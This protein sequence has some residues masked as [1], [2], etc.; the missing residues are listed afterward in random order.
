MID[1]RKSWRRRSRVSA[2][3]IPPAAYGQC[4]RWRHSPRAADRPPPRETGGGHSADGTCS[5]CRRSRELRRYSPG[6]SHPAPR[7]VLRRS[8]STT[9]AMPSRT[10]ACREDRGP[11]RVREAKFACDPGPGCRSTGLLSTRIP[12]SRR[13][14]GTQACRIDHSSQLAKRLQIADRRLINSRP[15]HPEKK[16]RDS[17]PDHRP[18]DQEH[19]LEQVQRRGFGVVQA[20]IAHRGRRPGSVRSVEVPQPQTPA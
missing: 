2:G 4:G 19:V 10:S 1:C 3:C 7:C 14:R 16:I 17:P 11:R 20:E 6:R 12:G 18:L 9:V 15:V 8:R 13:H 5:D